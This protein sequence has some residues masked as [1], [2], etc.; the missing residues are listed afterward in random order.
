VVEVVVVE[1]V[2]VEDISC[3][4]L[5][6]GLKLLPQYYYPLDNLYLSSCSESRFGTKISAF[7]L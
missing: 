7:L 2:V 6:Q 5:L 1:V 3:H 4:F